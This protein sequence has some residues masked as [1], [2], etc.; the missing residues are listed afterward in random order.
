M[1][2]SERSFPSMMKRPWC[3]Q[4]PIMVGELTNSGASG[5]I[6]WAQSYKN[7]HISVRDDGSTDNTV[8]IL[9]EY[10]S[11]YPFIRVAY[12]ENLGVIESFFRL[13]A[14]TEGDFDYFAFCDQDDMWLPDKIKDAVGEINREDG[15]QPILFFF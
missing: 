11:K 12:G 5:E 13:L 2:R 4:W 10:A 14:D 15:Y 6:L 9:K 1:R 7:I 3:G 8:H